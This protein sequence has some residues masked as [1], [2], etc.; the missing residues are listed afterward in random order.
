MI[1]K[2]GKEFR[3]LLKRSVS[4]RDRRVL[5]IGLDCMTP[6]FLFDQ[7]LD[8]LPTIKRLVESSIHGPLK[9]CIPPITVPAWACMT[10][11]KNPGQLGVYGF[12]NRFDRSYD[13]L[14]IATSQ[15]IQEDRIWDTLSQAGKKAIIVGVPQTYPPKPINGY[16]ITSILTPNTGCQYTHPPELREEVERLVGE[17]IFDVENFRTDDKEH[18][19]KQIY[20]MTQ[21]RFTVAKHLLQT[22]P[23]DFF[24]MVEIGL[25][26][27]HHAFWKYSDPEHRKHEPGS[28]YK[29]AI[30]DYYKYLDQEIEALLSL[31]D[32]PTITIIVSDHGAQAME[33][34]VCINEW[35]IQEGYLTLLE[36]PPGIV[37]LAKAKINWSRTACWGEGGYYS[38]IFFNVK[39][40]EPQGVISP[41]NYQEVRNE[42][43]QKLKAMCDEKGTPLGNRVFKPEEV[44]PVANGIPPELIVYFGN[45]KWRSVGSIG[46]GTTLTFENDIGPDDANHAEHGV[47]II[48]D[49]LN[50][51]SS[52]PETKE[53]LNILDISPTIL[54]LMGLK[55]PEGMEGKI[56]TT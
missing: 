45:L 13:G 6:Q 23:W 8:Q 49:P 24:M 48:H 22:K 9:S 56:I 7:W 12:R 14:T 30:L 40:R 18:L 50:P 55:V 33:G 41:H 52:S 43:A 11:S 4:L 20:Q 26:R 35:L 37:S 51:V 38:R 53:D 25:D 15:E 17:Y 32:D 5:V 2:T 42:I 34:G 28:P 44:Y 27:I 1:G 47:C 39:G 36:K 46:Y 21:K 54:N 10:T 31:I 3:H 19:L 29:N 16:M